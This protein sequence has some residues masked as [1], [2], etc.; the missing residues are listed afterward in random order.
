M[1]LGVTRERARQLEDI[2][3]ARL[4]EELR[5]VGILKKDVDE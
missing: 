2:A 1:A 5:K 3:K 4:E